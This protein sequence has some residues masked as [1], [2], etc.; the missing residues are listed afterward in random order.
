MQVEQLTS[1]YPK[2]TGIELTNPLQAANYQ[3]YLGRELNY[4]WFDSE[5]G[6]NP[7]KVAALSGCLLPGGLLILSFEQVDKDNDLNNFMPWQNEDKPYISLFN[8]RLFNLASK[9]NRVITYYQGAK[10]KAY[11]VE[12]LDKIWSRPNK[13]TPEQVNIVNS[14]GQ[15]SKGHFLITADRGRGKSVCLAQLALELE[16]IHPSKAIYVTAPSKKNL[17]S[18]F[19]WHNQHTIVSSQLNYIAPD[20]LAN[21]AKQIDFLLIDEAAAIPE[22]LRQ[23]IV[24]KARHV[25]YATTLH[26]YEGSGQTFNLKFKQFLTRHDCGLMEYKLTTPIRWSENDPLEGWLNRTYLLSTDN[27]SYDLS[28]NIKIDWVSPMQLMNDESELEQIFGLLSQAHYRTT[29]S[30][31]R[32]ILDSP[33]LLI[34]CIKNDRNQVVASALISQEGKLEPDLTA[35]ILKGERRPKGHLLPQSVIV[36][37]GLTQF[38]NML[39]WRIVRI[40]VQPNI[41]TLGL[42][43]KLLQWLTKEATK[44]SEIEYIATSFSSTDNL[45]TF[46]KKQ[47]FDLIRTGLTRDKASANFSVI[48]YKPIS[49]LANQLNTKLTINCLEQINYYLASNYADVKPSLL[50]RWYSALSPNIAHDQI[51]DKEVILLVS[52]TSADIYSFKPKLTNFCIMN[53]NTLL[54]KL[55]ENESDLLAHYFLKQSPIEKICE[56]FKFTG[57]KQLTHNIRKILVKLCS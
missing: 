21:S 19:E 17:D 40:A 39:G 27:S 43:S 30:D 28:K 22:Q 11:K 49:S 57:K 52:T 54:L 24:T 55:S 4:L 12:N 23:Q 6:I 56:M 10:N 2:D 7:D 29:P 8:Q 53:A 13:L 42:G 41:Q 48:M 3:N 25:T 44:N 16:K 26:G 18:F 5:Y 20:A 37:S 50:W 47:N 36:S 33:S 14:I 32:Y 31:L 45:L 35:Q 38:A 51:I 34:A 46:W 15:Q 1:L 9:N